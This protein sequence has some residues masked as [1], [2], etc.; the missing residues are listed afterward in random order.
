VPEQ[1]FELHQQ[2]YA[3]VYASW[4]AS[5]RGPAPV[6]VPDQRTVQQTNVAR[7]METFQVQIFAKFVSL[8]ATASAL[9]HDADV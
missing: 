2:L 4:R 8:A 5:E 3:A 9:L 1:P 6:W 7:F